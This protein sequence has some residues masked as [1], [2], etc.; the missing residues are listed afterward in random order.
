MQYGTCIT[1]CTHHKAS[2]SPKL[3]NKFCFILMVNG[4][5]KLKKCITQPVFVSER[6]RTLIHASKFCSSFLLWRN[7]VTSNVDVK[8]LIFDSF[9]FSVINKVIFGKNCEFYKCTY[10]SIVLCLK[11]SEKWN[12]F[13]MTQHHKSTKFCPHIECFYSLLLYIQFCGH[14]WWWNI[15]CCKISPKL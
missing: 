6:T 4:E 8:R 7:K 12:F 3:L 14:A 1:P 11:T 5:Y 9:V 10:A 13:V 15:S 2:C